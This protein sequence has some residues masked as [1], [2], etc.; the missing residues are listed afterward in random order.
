MWED[1]ILDRAFHAFDSGETTTEARQLPSDRD[2]HRELD[3]QAR[4]NSAGNDADF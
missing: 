1:E 2:A 3:W 4:S